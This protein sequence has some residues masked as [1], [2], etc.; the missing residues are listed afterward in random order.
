MSS[1]PRFH[2]SQSGGPS[3]SERRRAGRRIFRRAL[4]ASLVLH[5]VLL[6][7]YPVLVGPPRGFLPRSPGASAPLPDGL[8]LMALRELPPGTDPEV[9]AP[10]PPPEPDRSEAAPPVPPRAPSPGAQTAPPGEPGPGAGAATPTEEEARR[11]S[12]A[13]LLR[14]GAWDPELFGPL[15]LP[16]LSDEERY[17][18]QLAGK[19]EQWQDS[20]RQEMERERR[21]VDWTHTDDE[22]NRWGVSPGRIHLGKITLP[23]PFNFGTPPGRRDEIERRAWETEEIMRGSIQGQILETQ[24]D[25]AREIRARREAERAD[26][27][28]P[29]RL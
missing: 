28:P 16:A 15:D 17:R 5:A 9:P 23:L 7:L 1:P 20:V 14:P 12:A 26:T 29:P 11:R 13:E 24:R 22:G 19:L 6:G 18:L 4:V 27:L 25:R 2:P 21:A 8:Q 10:D 3:F